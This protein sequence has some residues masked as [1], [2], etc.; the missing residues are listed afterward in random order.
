MCF[1][2]R[3]CRVG[4][5]PVSSEVL[6]DSF[7]GVCQI[8]GHEHGPI[9]LPLS[10]TLSIKCNFRPPCHM[11]MECFLIQNP[12]QPGFMV[13]PSMKCEPVLVELVTCVKLCLWVRSE[14]C[15]ACFSD[16]PLVEGIAGLSSAMVDC[17]CLVAWSS[18]SAPCFMFGEELDEMSFV[19]RRPSKSW[20]P[21]R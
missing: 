7:V 20:V 1:L 5:D 13:F 8:R 11:A 16:C 10:N 4:R 6:G 18:I 21:R 9:P 12:R 15:P 19:A 2:G 14:G 3:R 17:L